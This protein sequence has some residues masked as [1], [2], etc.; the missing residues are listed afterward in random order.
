M[1]ERQEHARAMA[2]DLI[3]DYIIHCGARRGS[4]QDAGPAIL[5]AS[6]SSVAPDA[7]DLCLRALKR[8]LND[9]PDAFTGVGAFGG[10]GGLLSGLRT[11]TALSPAVTPAY[12]ALCARTNEWL[13]QQRWRHSSVTWPDYDLFFGPAGVV[14]AGLSVDCPPDMV[15]PA[16]R[17]LIAMAATEGL[18]AFRG[19]PEIDQRSAFN[20]GRINTGLGH[21]LTGVASALN[22]AIRVAGQENAR[23]A[24]RRI[25]EWLVQQTYVD[26]TGLVTWPPAGRLP[27]D[28][29]VTHRRQA[30]CYGTPGVSWTLWEAAD[31]L[32]DDAMRELAEE[33]MVSFCDVFD[34]N[35]L[36]HD[37]AGEDIAVCHGAAGIL[38]IA[39]A[40]ARHTTV[41]TAPLR[42]R[43]LDY[44]IERAARVRD[45]GRRDMSL[46]TGAGGMAAV[47]LTATGADRQ[48]L[49][50]IAVR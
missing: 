3:T 28:A 14:R 48:W 38:A 33:A 26:K 1:T 22:H 5:A 45:H 13:T 30:W 39:D 25:C 11:A 6:L 17:H 7:K 24:L 2:V 46:L 36:D 16:L 32:A 40:Y 23:P 4:G 15:V 35:R 19:G 9:V 31:T 50:H 41:A 8:W 18:L 34:E 21:G 29:D 10:L 42:D 49:H 12:S 37:D 47:A 27:E 43:M 20:I 44:L